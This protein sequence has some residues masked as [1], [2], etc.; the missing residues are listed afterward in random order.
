MRACQ[1]HTLLCALPWLLWAVAPGRPA[2]PP[3]QSAALRGAPSDPARGAD[4]N[5][6]YSGVVNLST[7]NIYSFNYT[8]QPGQVTAVRVYVNSSSENLNYPVLVV[9]RQQKEVLSWQ[10][11]L[12]FQGL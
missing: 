1:R 6:V 7:E 4:F 10:V 11:P 5:H 3:T 12:L 9:V 2:K 8:S